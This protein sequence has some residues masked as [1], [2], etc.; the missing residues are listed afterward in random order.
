MTGG[1][2]AKSQLQLPAHEDV[3]QQHR[4]ELLLL[5]APSDAEC[6]EDR[7]PSDLV[8][9]ERRLAEL[10][11][12]DPRMGDDHVARQPCP[13]HSAE[14]VNES[15]MSMIGSTPSPGPVGTMISP[16]S[17]TNGAVMSCS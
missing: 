7:P 8:R 12:K 2:D 6:L 14:T 17:S 5:V 10:H 15:S 13:S 16:S 1:I 4:R 3:D 11:L 9:R